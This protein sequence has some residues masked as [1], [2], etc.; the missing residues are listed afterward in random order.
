MGG[1]HPP[2]YSVGQGTDVLFE[3]F[4]MMEAV[5]W[6]LLAVKNKHVFKPLPTIVRAFLLSQ[7]RVLQSTGCPRCKSVLLC[8]VPMQW[9]GRPPL[10]SG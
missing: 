4:A 10:E 2:S 6:D 7:H 8:L 3:H 5:M 1:P 9:P